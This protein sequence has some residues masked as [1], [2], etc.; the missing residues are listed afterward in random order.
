LHECS[1]LAAGFPLLTCLSH[2]LDLLQSKRHAD[3]PIKAAILT[4]QI[5]SETL[6]GVPE[7]ELEKVSVSGA[8]IAS[9]EAR[10]LTSAASSSSPLAK[11][12]PFTEGISAGSIAQGCVIC[13][14]GEIE[15]RLALEGMSQDVKVCTA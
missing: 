12:K 9:E 7:A 6:L 3:K 10:K 5:L 2:C 14:E 11:P 15:K 8:K 4:L 13:E 1:L